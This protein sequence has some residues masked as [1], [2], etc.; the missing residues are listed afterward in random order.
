[1]TL[2]LRDAF[3]QE[4]HTGLIPASVIDLFCGCGALSYGFRSE[5]FHVA[6]GFDI[7]ESCRYPYE[8]NVDTPFIRTDVRRLKKQDLIRELSPN[9]ASVVVGCA[10]CQPFSSYGQ[11]RS[12]KDWELIRVFGHL[13]SESKPDV[14]SMENVPRLLTFQKGRVFRA[15]VKQLERSSYNVRWTVAFGP[16]FGL[17]QSRSRLVLIASRLGEPLLPKPSVEPTHHQTVRDS[18]GDLPYLTAGGMDANDA[19]HRCCNL[20]PL[21]LKR[22]KSSH[23]GGTWRDWHPELV[24]DCHKSK[25]GA[26]YTSVYGRMHWDQPSP[27]ITTQFYGYGRGRFGHPEQDRGLSLREGANLQSFPRSFRFTRSDQEINIARV[28][29]QI[30]NAVPVIL[31]KAIAKAI[32]LHLTEVC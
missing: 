23:P 19:L 28:G 13:I 22:I 10:P 3:R 26:S 4:A 7:D 17:A 16:D 18:I 29:R 15:F 24:A 25:S 14:V 12:G 2:S 9:A 30:G 20:S 32:A 8:T 31:A 1:M 21:N 5:G 11:H 27:T 6:C